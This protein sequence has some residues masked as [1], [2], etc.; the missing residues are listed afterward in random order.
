MSSHHTVPVIGQDGQ[1]LTPTTP[2]RA[3][4]LVRS[5][6]AKPFSTKLNTWAL[7]MVVP[8]RAARVTTGDRVEPG[9]LD[10]VDDRYRPVRRH[11]HDSKTSK[12]RHRIPYSR[13]TVRGLRKGLLIGTPTGKRGRL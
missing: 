2:A 5:G 6:Q 13:G 10:I 12:G 3:R 7:H 9:P 1:P 8:T 11:L 4:K